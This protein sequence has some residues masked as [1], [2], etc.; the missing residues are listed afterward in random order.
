MSELCY[1]LREIT[2]VLW[3]AVLTVLLVLLLRRD[4]RN[5]AM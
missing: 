4:R 5:D 1:Y 3:L 2:E